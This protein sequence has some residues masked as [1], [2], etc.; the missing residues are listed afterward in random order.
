MRCPDCGSDVNDGAKFC[1]KCG[2]NMD[3]GT[4]SQPKTGSANESAQASAAHDASMAMP[5]EASSRYAKVFK[6]LIYAVLAVLAVVVVVFVV[7]GILAFL[8]FVL[9]GVVNIV[10]N[11]VALAIGGFLFYCLFK[12][13][14]TPSPRSEQPGPQRKKPTGFVVGL[15]RGVQEV[16]RQRDQQAA[17]SAAS[18][19]DQQAAGAAYARQQQQDRQRE[20][21]AK[22]KDMYWQDQQAKKYVQGSWQQRQHTNAA[23][24]DESYLKWH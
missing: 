12:W 21:E 22:K 4:T 7:R 14:V 15:A 18:R 8:G 11:A 5:D 23:D 6:Y 10:A 17:A 3:A 2:R 16:Q 20:R 24:R 13:L 1:P 19:R 9:T